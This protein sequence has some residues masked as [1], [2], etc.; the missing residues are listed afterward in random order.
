MRNKFQEHY[1][2]QHGFRKAHSSATA[3]IDIVDSAY[4]CYDDP[5]NIG[6]SIISFDMS[7]AFDTIQHALILEKLNSLS[8]SKGFLLWLQSYLKDRKCLVKV[9]GSLSR[10]IKVLKGVPQGSVLG[11]AIFATFT[12][13]LMCKNPNSANVMYADDIT[14]V[15]PLGADSLDDEVL[16]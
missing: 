12:S 11:P 9:N 10:E 16:K 4:R 2:P 13:D 15:A 3:L 14:L 6:T 1:G 7:S 8:Y 5:C